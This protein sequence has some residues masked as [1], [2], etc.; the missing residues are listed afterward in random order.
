MNYRDLFEG[1]E[2]PITLQNGSY[3]VPINFDNGATTP[4]FKSVINTILEDI[5]YY[6]PIARG[7]G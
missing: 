4:P 3:V 1:I 2:T 6:G 7:L 5:K